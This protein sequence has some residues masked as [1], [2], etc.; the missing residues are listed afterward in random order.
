MKNHVLA[1]FTALLAIPL[2][3]TAQAQAA[4]LTA[5]STLPRL[6]FDDTTSA[7]AGTEFSL[8]CGGYHG[9]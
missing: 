2:L 5:S 3:L 8:W 6:W 9:A 7:F 4:D 1:S